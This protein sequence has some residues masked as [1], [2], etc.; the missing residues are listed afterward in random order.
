VLTKPTPLGLDEPPVH[1]LQ[2]ACFRV[3]FAG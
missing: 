1:I 2:I 3:L